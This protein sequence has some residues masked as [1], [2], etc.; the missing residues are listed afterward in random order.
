MLK[1]LTIKM[2]KVKKDDTATLTAQAHS[3]TPSYVRMVVNGKRNNEAILT[4]F[5]RILEAK[6]NIVNA[7][8]TSSES[9]K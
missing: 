9:H 6:N 4:T 5:N 7:V 1:N 3:V 2:E 8:F